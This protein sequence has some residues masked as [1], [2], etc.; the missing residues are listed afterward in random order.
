MTRFASVVFDVDST[1]SSI[2]GIDWLAAQRGPEIAQ[3]CESLTAEAMA[4][5]LPLE[6]VYLQRLAAIR[7]TAAELQALGAEYCRTVQPGAAELIAAL[8]AQGVRV[9]LVSGG[10]R[11][12]LLPL[13]AQLGVPATALHAV[14]VAPDDEGC[15]TLLDGDQP[16]ATQ[17]GKPHVVHYLALPAPIAMIGDGST[18]AAVRDVAHCTFI[19][20]TGVA[21]RAAVVE[22]AAAE[23]P[24]FDALAALLFTTS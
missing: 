8:Q 2:E 7:P 17:R 20:Y 18:D 21:R 16:L 4:G 13:A 14:E 1:L 6:A 12:A 19:A 9:H 24:S 10:L 22:K 3:R 15:L 5:A 11:A 23:A